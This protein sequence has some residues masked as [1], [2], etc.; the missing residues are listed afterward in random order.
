MEPVED[1]S[2]DQTLPERVIKIGTKILIKLR[3]ELVNFLR[4]FLDVFAW[5]P[6]NMPRI[7]EEIALHLL[8]LKP[9]VHAVK[10]KKRVFFTK[11]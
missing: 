5:E 2:L 1:I 11:K 9:G 10:Q 3:G 6:K 7:P 8:N 4:E